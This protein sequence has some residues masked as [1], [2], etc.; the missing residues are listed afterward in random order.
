[1]AADKILLRDYEDFLLLIPE[2]EGPSFHIIRSGRLITADDKI[3]YAGEEGEAAEKALREFSEKAAAEGKISERVRERGNGRII[4]PPFANTH[5][6]I[7]MSLFRGSP[8]NYNLQDWLTQWIFPREAKLTPEIVRAGADLAIAEMIKS[9]TAASADMYFFEEMTAEAALDAGFRLN[10]ALG[11]R[12]GQ[13]A[14]E[15]PV[16]FAAA[17]H[18]AEKWKNHPFIRTSLH[19]HSLYLY[20]EDLYPRL[21]ELCKDLNIPVQIHLAETAL[22]VEDLRK[23]YGKGPVRVLKDFGLLRD[24]SLLAHCVW[25]GEEDIELLR[26]REVYIA[27]NPASNC[28]LGSGICDTERLFDAGLKVTLG[29]DGAGSNDSLNMFR[30]LRLASFL[31]KAVRRDASAAEPGKWLRAAT[32]GGYEALG[33][34]EAG[35]LRAGAAAD[36]MIYNPDSVFAAPSGSYTDPLSLLV[37]AGTAEAAESLLVAGKYIMKNRELL[38]LDEEKIIFEAKKAAAYLSK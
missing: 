24:Q 17:E 30:D 31:P 36:F 3:L 23:K 2:E 14:D 11:A 20:P 18:Y 16:D 29:T 5:C 12:N 10:L 7:A 38:T 34:A 35:S 15:P 6:H 27:H 22:E 33:F 1:M 21:G 8:A 25:L 37:Y 26:G 9:G 13:A 32:Y 4:L 19:V 28:K